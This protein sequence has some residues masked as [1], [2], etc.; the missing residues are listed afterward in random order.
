MQN[1]I[2]GLQGL[3]H[4]QV[5]ITIRVLPFGIIGYIGDTLI[6]LVI[7]CGSCALNY[8]PH[9]LRHHQTKIFIFPQGQMPSRSKA[10]LMLIYSRF[11]VLS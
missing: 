8:V 1:L 11:L 10:A 4:F 3:V 7:L 5:T 6:R 9:N 2:T